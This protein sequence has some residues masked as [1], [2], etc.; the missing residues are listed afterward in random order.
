M[1]L[2][3]SKIRGGSQPEH[4]LRGPPA[5][6]TLLRNYL[7][8]WPP[9]TIRQ[10]AAR[11]WVERSERGWVPGSSRPQA[12]LEEGRR[13]ARPLAAP[14]GFIGIIGNADGTPYPQE[15]LQQQYDIMYGQC[16]AAHGN[17]V[18][19]LSLPPGAAPYS[20]KFSTYSGGPSP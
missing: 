17:S 19:S 1:L 8:P 18:A 3:Q 15:S 20:G 5:S 9:L 12:T 13:L 16:M 2:H 14:S 4:D 10:S 7:P 6:K 11:Y